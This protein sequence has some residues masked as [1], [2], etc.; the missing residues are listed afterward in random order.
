MARRRKKARYTWLPIRGQFN[1][2]D[3]PTFSSYQDAIVPV[4]DG[5][6]SLGIL[7]LLQDEPSEDEV[8]LQ[9]ESMSDLIGSEYVVKR[10]VGKMFCQLRIQ[11]IGGTG[12][13]EPSTHGYAVH[14]KTGIFVARSE[15]ELAIPVGWGATAE[16]NYNP[17]NQF[18]NREPWLFQRSWILGWRGLF[19]GPS[20]TAGANPTLVGSWARY[21]NSMS[22]PS[23]NAD[24]GSINDGPH[25]DIR[26]ARRVKQDDRLWWVVSVEAWP[27]KNQVVATA[28]TDAFL[29]FDYR[30]LGALRRARPSSSF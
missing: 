18:N 3:T 21:Y 19:S 5:A 27:D 12:F 29:R 24:Y 28:G 16:P 9:H 1:E 8:E 30:A 20:A 13:L 7:P 17:L 11:N 22:W 10:I 6:P 4:I 14:V 26:V 15:S 23:S 25:I 2:E